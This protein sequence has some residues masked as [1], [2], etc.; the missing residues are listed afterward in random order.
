MSTSTN[1]NKPTIL[2]TGGTGFAGSHLVEALLNDD[3]TNVHVTSYG[4][5][6]SFVGEKLPKEQIHSINLTNF[7]DTKKLLAKIKPDQVYH[8]AALAGVGSSFDQLKKVIDLNTQI[9]LSVLIAAKE[10]TPNSRILSIGSALE[11]MPQ[12]RPLKETDQL[13]PVSPYGVSKVSQDMLSYSFFR[14]HNLDIVRTRSFN[15]LGER[16]TSGFVAVDFAQQV[17]R[18]MHKNQ[19]SQESIKVG[20]LSAVRDFTDVKDTVEAYITLMNAGE[21]GEVYNVGSGQGYSIQS[22]LDQLIKLSK[23]DIQVIIDQDRMRPI[24]VPQ[25]VADISKIKKLG[26]EPT[27]TIK[28]S[29][30]RVLEYQLK[31]INN[32]YR[33]KR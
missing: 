27:I 22:I 11:Y 13:G 15:H 24:D 6:T 4:H 16:Q 26:W 29:L 3:Q 17:A 10:E 21:A 31:K 8:L 28:K 9:Q 19:E 30:Q 33:H 5:E 23:K 2:I 14:Q 20:N 25:V 32:A 7:A 12:N 1:N 18:I